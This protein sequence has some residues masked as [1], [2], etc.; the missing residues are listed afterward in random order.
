VDK[1]MR[2][3][4][5]IATELR[6]VRA[7][8]IAMY[9]N[10]VLN[11]LAASALLDVSRMKPIQFA[12]G[13]V[14]AESGAPIEGIVFPESGLLSMVNDLREG[15]RVEVGMV[16]RDGLIG[17]AVALG[18]VCSTCSVFVQI[19]GR[20]WLMKASDAVECANG[21]LAFRRLLHL[22]EHR[23]LAQARQIAACNVK[24]VI[25]QRLCSWLLRARASLG[26]GELLVTQESLAQM[27]GVQRASVCMVASQLQEAGLIQYRRGRVRIDDAAGLARQACECHAV[28][29]ENLKIHDTVERPF[30]DEHGTR[31]LA[32]RAAMDEP[33]E[34][35]IDPRR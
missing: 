25:M 34:R 8:D 9:N 12:H 20:G 11:D 29:L 19:A 18:S 5:R 1:A 16:G 28:L 26:E 6:S 23:A 35:S 14:L 30:R 2:F 7:R 17:G 15:D 24:H 32:D 31:G 13:D 10:H 4:G 22:H 33:G 3:S 21:S 27:L